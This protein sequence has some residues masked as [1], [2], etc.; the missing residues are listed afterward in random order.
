MAITELV[1]P[2]LKAE[3]VIRTNFYSKIPSLLRDTFKV[4]DGPNAS[5]VARILKSTPAN[6]ENHK[7]YLAVFSWE[8]LE[9]IQNFL[10]T[11]EFVGFKSSLVDY[12]DGP[13]VLQFFEAAP[14]VV[15][16]NTL[17][18]STHF[19]VVKAAGTE[20]QVNQARRYWG[21][22]TSTFSRIAGDEV[23]YHSGDG[24]LNYDGQFSGFSGWKS[25]EAL[26]EALGQSEVQDQLQ[27]L[28]ETCGSVS[29]FVLELKHVF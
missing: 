14:G 18:G 28:F 15:P 8:S 17:H 24:K 10:K 29:S 13:P 23:K 12:V 4:S 25:I 20:E 26:N 9:K 21:G 3:E 16:E 6:A 1:F 5:A 22:I 7:G 11:P 2:P 19:F 27:A